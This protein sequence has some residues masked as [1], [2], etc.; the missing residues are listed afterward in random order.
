MLIE[1]HNPGRARDGLGIRPRRRR[2]GFA[3]MLQAAMRGGVQGS[4]SFVRPDT[5]QA[6]NLGSRATLD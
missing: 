5:V 2:V 4:V 6:A 1:L 3:P